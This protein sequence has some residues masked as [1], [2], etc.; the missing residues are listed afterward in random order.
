MTVYDYID[1]PERELAEMITSL[2]AALDRLAPPGYGEKAIATIP[3]GSG[4]KSEIIRT[5]AGILKSLRAD[6]AAGRM[7]TFQERV[8]SDLFSDFLEMA[9]YL[10]EDEG[11]KDPAAVLAGGVLEEHLRKLCVKHGVPVPPKPK[12][13]MLNADSEKAG[14][15]RRERTEAGHRL[16][17]NPQQAPPMRSTPITPTRTRRLS[18]APGP[19]PLPEQLPCPDAAPRREAHS[20]QR[21]FRLPL[22][23]QHR[24]DCNT[25]TQGLARSTASWAATASDVATASG[26]WP[27][28]LA[29]QD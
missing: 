25:S 5:L 27:P 3:T 26:C 18:D 12:L 10:L 16:G 6:H 21:H 17:R 13:D 14:S 2:R 15:L 1:A 19:P 20:G 11:L 4:F 7:Q 22:T 8:N 28:A 9:E 24:L 23:Q 29:A